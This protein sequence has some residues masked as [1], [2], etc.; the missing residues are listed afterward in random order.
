MNGNMLIVSREN[1][2]DI[3]K[4]SAKDFGGKL[5]LGLGRTIVHQTV[6]AERHHRRRFE[7]PARRERGEEEGGVRGKREGVIFYYRRLSLT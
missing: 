5:M 3:F 7:L 2:G 1:D 6:D 4:V